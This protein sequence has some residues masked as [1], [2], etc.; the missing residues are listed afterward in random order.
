LMFKL[1]SMKLLF[2]RSRNIQINDIYKN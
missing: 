2:E 1:S